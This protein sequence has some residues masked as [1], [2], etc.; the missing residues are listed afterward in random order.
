MS[1]TSRLCFVLLTSTGCLLATAGLVYAVTG[2]FV[3]LNGEYDFHLFPKR[4]PIRYGV[5]AAHRA[6]QVFHLLALTAT[7]FTFPLFVVSVSGALSSLL[8][9]ELV[10]AGLFDLACTLH[11]VAL[12]TL[13]KSAKDYSDAIKG[14]PLDLRIEPAA[15]FDALAYLGLLLAGVCTT[16]RAWKTAS[17][18]S[19]RIRL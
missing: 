2:P 12:G 1:R 6:S 16:H 4:D 17:D 18:V 5:S 15:P 7:L 13:A 9:L 19:G 8:V 14:I 11:L 3:S 10:V